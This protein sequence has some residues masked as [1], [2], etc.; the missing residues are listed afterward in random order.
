MDANDG[1]VNSCAT[2]TPGIDCSTSGSV[3]GVFA[4]LTEDGAGEAFRGGVFP[5]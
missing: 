3:A 1:R 4:S 2:P 5:T